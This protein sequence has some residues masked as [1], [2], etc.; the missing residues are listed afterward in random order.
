MSRGRAGAPPAKPIVSEAASSADR[1]Q[2]EEFRARHADEGDRLLYAVDHDLDW[3]AERYI[4][5][6]RDAATQGMG[7][8]L[9]SATAWHV[10]GVA[11]ITDLLVAPNARRRGIARALV[12]E[13]E[14]RARLASC[15]RMHAVTV[16]GS[17]AERF[18][19][20]MGWETV[21]VL[22]DYYFGRDHVVLSRPLA[23]RRRAR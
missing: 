5:L 13:F 9:G 3:E 19:N 18:W 6:A 23:K 12:E 10:G 14:R 2:V 11:K 17:G 15:H 7:A 1:S 4:L 22:T 16:K 20:A 8:I 21:A